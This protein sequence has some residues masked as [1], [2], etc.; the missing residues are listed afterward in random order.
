MNTWYAY[1]QAVVDTIDQSIQSGDDEALTLGA[2]AAHLGYSVFHTTRKFKELSGIPL[3]DYL[4]LRRLAFALIDLRDTPKPILD[5]AVQYGFSSHEAFTRAF[6]NAYGMTPSAYRRQPVPVVL[7]TKINTLDRYLLGIG[8]IGMIQSDKTIK[9]YYA[10]IPAHQFLHI[11]N[12]DSDGYF[13]F[14][15]RQKEIPGQDCDTICGLLDSIRGK[16]DGDDHVVGQF[17]GQI[18]AHLYEADGRCAE[19]YGVRLPADYRGT[20]PE[21]MLC[22]DVPEGEYIVFEHGSFDYEN[23]SASV[24]EKLEEAMQTYDFGQGD[25]ALD[26]T[27][28]RLAYFYF[29]P[30]KFEKRIQPVRKP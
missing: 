30:E 25:Y 24:G 15:E 26:E 4:R 3:R 17:S 28:G 11:K 12:Y 21:Q 5:I 13:D 23:E 29:D 27:P 18:M 10:S 19:A 1:I 8:E 2:L 14:W 16:L 7:R 6:K 9:I 20:I 22:L